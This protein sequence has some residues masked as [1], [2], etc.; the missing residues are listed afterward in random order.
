MNRDLQATLKELGPDYRRLVRE[1][2]APFEDRPAA[3]ARPR[4]KIGYLAAAILAAVFGL[5]VWFRS[6]P[7]PRT[8]P[9]IYTIAYAATPD[10]LRTIVASQQA[11]GSWENDFLTRQNAAALQN[12]TIPDQ[13]IAYLKAVRYLRRKGLAPFTESELSANRE[14]GAPAQ[15]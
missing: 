7:A 4:W 10:A 1:M 11:D 2:K 8:A 13:R 9:R 14:Q 5:T 3:H 12:A 6:A 15:N